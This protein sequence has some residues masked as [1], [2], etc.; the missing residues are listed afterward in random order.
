MVSSHPCL[1]RP[2]DNLMARADCIVCDKWRVQH[3]T[4]RVL[5]LYSKTS[6][7]ALL[8]S[9]DASGKR[10]AKPHAVRRPKER[11]LNRL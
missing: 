3:K 4:W 5:D 10:A 1:Q 9:L 2:G 7:I 8:M 6:K 11:V